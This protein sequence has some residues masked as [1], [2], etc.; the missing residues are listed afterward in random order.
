MVLALALYAIALSAPR[1]AF[2]P[3]HWQIPVGEGIKKVLG[4][5]DEAVICIVLASAVLAYWG[6]GK[7]KNRLPIWQR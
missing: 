1:L 4:V 7:G 3:G 6:H 2:W 5:P